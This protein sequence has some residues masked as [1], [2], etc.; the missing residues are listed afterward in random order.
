M[1]KSRKGSKAKRIK[2]GNRTS[3]KFFYE[4]VYSLLLNRFAVCLNMVMLIVMVNGYLLVSADGN[5]P[6]G[7]QKHSEYSYFPCNSESVKY[8]S[9]S[10]ISYLLSL[11]KP[12]S[13]QQRMISAGGDIQ[14]AFGK[15]TTPAQATPIAAGLLPGWFG[16]A[17]L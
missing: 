13:M 7:I 9:V 17:A 5:Y 15:S 6:P 12:A 10:V 8:H 14:F 3:I 16:Y 2:T 11:I 1:K 4:I